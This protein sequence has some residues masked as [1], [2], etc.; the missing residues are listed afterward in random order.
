MRAGNL[1]H[2]IKFY[3]KVISRDDYGA[4][5]D[6]WPSV[7]II[8]RG[9]VRWVGGSRVLSNEER[10][11]DRTMEFKNSWEFSDLKKSA[12]SIS[13]ELWFNDSK[14]T[15]FDTSKF[16][17]GSIYS[18]PRDVRSNLPSILEGKRSKLWISVERRVKFWEKFISDMFS[19]GK[20]E[21]ILNKHFSKRGF[22]KG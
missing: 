4:S 11:Y 18:T 13:R 10:M 20:L 16:I 19:G 1:Y 9:E 7:T 22:V 3:A 8:T 17:H 15:T 6:T 2:R 21:Q 12:M 14:M 5:S